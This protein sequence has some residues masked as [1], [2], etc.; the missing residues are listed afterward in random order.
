MA[1][2]IQQIA[3]GGLHSLVLLS[4]GSVWATG[5]NSS[6]QLGDG[7]HQGGFGWI[8]V[9]AAGSGVIQIATG[10][11]HSLALKSDGSVWATGHNG[12]GQLGDS[13]STYNQLTWISLISAGVTQVAAGRGYSL[14]LKSDGSV[15]AT[16]RNIIG[17]LGDGTNKDRCRW[18]RVIASGVTQLA[19]GDDH[20]FALKSDGSVW[21]TGRND[22]GQL[23]D[24]TEETKKRWMPVIPLGS[25]VVQVAAGDDHSLALKSDGSLL[26]TGWNIY[27]QLG[28]G[29]TAYKATWTSVIPSGVTQVAAGGYHSLALKSDGAA[30]ATGFN[31][32]GQIGNG[33]K[34]NASAWQSVIY[35]GVTQVAVGRGYSLALKSDG[36]LW[37][38]GK[39]NCGQLGHEGDGNTI[40]IPD[41]FFEKLLLESLMG[42]PRSLPDRMPDAADDWPGLSL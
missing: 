41:R 27:G 38:T 30:W 19:A 33:T 40:W 4:D 32:D 16:G 36:T 9:M 31:C 1:L 15:W 35:T 5:D 7:T 24:G 8:P 22:L 25:D 17:Q 28:N 26:A 6:G 42:D 23:G 29:V 39:N 34:M 21:A 18:T 20:S 37:K 13:T 14:A 12:Y 3:G 11:M 2:H 10:D